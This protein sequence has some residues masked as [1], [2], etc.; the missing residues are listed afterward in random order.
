MFQW[1]IRD[2][3]ILVFFLHQV[4]VDCILILCHLVVDCHDLLLFLKTAAVGI[5]C[6]HCYIV[7]DCLCLQS[8]YIFYYLCF[9]VNDHD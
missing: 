5:V 7:P 1:L 4:V 3:F 9:D 8:K 2:I 6:S